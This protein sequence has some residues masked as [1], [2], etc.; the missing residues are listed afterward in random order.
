M[1]QIEKKKETN[2]FAWKKKGRNKKKKKNIKI[3]LELKQKSNS[4]F[5]IQVDLRLKTNTR[6]KQQSIKIYETLQMRKI[7]NNQKLNLQKKNTRNI[8]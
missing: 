6:H 2:L 5:G 7:Q 8:D 1:V 4:G 3:T